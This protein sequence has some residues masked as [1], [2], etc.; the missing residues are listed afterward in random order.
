MQVTARAKINLCLHVGPPRPDGLHPVE[1]LC[2]FPDIGDRLTFSPAT[3]LSLSVQGPFAGDL[4]DLP[5]ADNLI[6]RAAKALQ[7]D[8]GSTAGAAITLEKNL[9][10]A[11]G[12]G[13]GSADL[14]AT[15]WALNRLWQ[16]DLTDQQL[17]Q[18]AFRLGADGPVCLASQDAPSRT[19]LAR[20]A[21]ELIAPGPSMD[22]AS[23][24]LVN[25][26]VATPTGEVFRRFDHLPPP[27]PLAITD[28]PQH[29]DYDTL[30]NFIRTHRNDLQPAAIDLVP[31]IK[32]VLDWLDSS[33]ADAVALSGSGATCFGVFRDSRRAGELLKDAADKGWW[34]S[35]GPVGTGEPK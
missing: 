30:I 28:L 25:P 13:G 19:V 6:I 24:L 4:A 34:A 10:A 12:M 11:S 5:Q 7:C 17:A 14:A 8:S 3:D 27:P 33:G 29:L 23:L 35:S 22:P 1:S 32:P 21:G 26:R 16:T 9:P 20:G 15:L 2:V 18:I 31:D